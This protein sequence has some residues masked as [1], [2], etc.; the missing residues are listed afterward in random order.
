LST[1]FFNYDVVDQFVGWVSELPDKS[2]SVTQQKGATPCVLGFGFSQPNLLFPRSNAPALECL[3]DNAYQRTGG[4]PK[5]LRRVVSDVYVPT[6]ERWNKG[7]I[8]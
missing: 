1:I 7:R 4:L 2:D 6:Q 8:A 3:S 5:G